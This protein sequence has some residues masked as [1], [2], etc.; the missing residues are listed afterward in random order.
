MIQE[1]DFWK[2]PDGTQRYSKTWLPDEAPHAV[3]QLVHGLGEHLGRYE[4]VARFF[5]DR[6]YAISAFDLRG[7]GKS[8]GVRGDVTSFDEAVQE[9]DARVAA[10]KERFAGLPLFVYGHSLGGALVLYYGIQCRPAVKGIV[11]SA[12]GLATANPPSRMTVMLARIMSKIAPTMQVDNGLDA[13]M[14]SRD[15]EVVRK[16][17]TDPL[18]HPKISARFGL[19]FIEKGSWIQAQGSFPVPLLVIQGG[20]DH[21][22]SPEVNGEFAKRLNGDVTL[23]VFEGLYHEPHNEPEQLEVLQTILDWMETR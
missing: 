8:E 19:D 17:Q 11:A 4:H 7:H 22:V 2:A 13:T 23:K 6:G 21:I 20:D 12:P 3:I 16:Y 15:K 18:V 5:T 14:V 9:I 10:A 1:E